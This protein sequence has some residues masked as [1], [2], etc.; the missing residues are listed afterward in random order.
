[1]ELLR[2]PYIFVLILVKIHSIYTG[3]IVRILHIFSILLIII[4]N[5]KPLVSNN[6][7]FVL[8]HQN[9]FWIKHYLPKQEV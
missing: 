7:Q 1:M 3:I 9:L 6:C 2:K 4:L 8:C 5:F